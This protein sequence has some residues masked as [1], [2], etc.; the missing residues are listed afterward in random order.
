MARAFQR[1]ASGNI[2]A[3]FEADE[4]QFLI[5]LID[6]FAQLLAPTAA[7]DALGLGIAETAQRSTDE[8]LARLLPDA[9]AEDAE[10][11]LEFRRLTEHDL[12]LKKLQALGEIRAGL[13]QSTGVVTLDAAAAGIWTTGIND[14]R[15]AVGTRLGLG[16]E[17]GAPPVPEL[18]PLYDWL[19]WMQDGLIDALTGDADTLA[20]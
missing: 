8:V 16:V 6:D 12:R 10:A 17:G 11:S 3:G 13:V 18:E 15:L 14:L 7:V 19:T 9:H 2:T 20:M 5:E 1:E 4:R